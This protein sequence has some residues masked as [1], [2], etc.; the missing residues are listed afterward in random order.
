MEISEF[1]GDVTTEIQLIDDNAHADQ[2]LFENLK[3]ILSLYNSPECVFTYEAISLAKQNSETIP[4]PSGNSSNYQNIGPRKEDSKV[5]KQNV[6]PLKVNVGKAMN[7]P[8]LVNSNPSLS[9]I[10][11]Q[12]KPQLPPS[13]VGLQ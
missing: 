4:G 1:E 11:T 2:N 5:V 8:H 7:L 3:K 10:S 6:V 13:P 9:N 12:N